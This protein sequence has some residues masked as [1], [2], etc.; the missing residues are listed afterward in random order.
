MARNA[1]PRAGEPGPQPDPAASRRPRQRSAL[2]RTHARPGTLGR[3]V[4]PALRN[5]LSAATASSMAA[6]SRWKRP[7]SARRA[8]RP[9]R[10][11]CGSRSVY[12][13]RMKP[14]LKYR[15]MLHVGVGAAML[16]ALSGCMTAKLEESRNTTT[17]IAAG[18]AVVLLAKPHVEGITAEDDFM[19]CVGNKLRHRPAFRCGRTTRSSTRCSPGSN[20]RRRRNARRA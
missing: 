4:A 2:R 3:S 10:W 16:L 15:S 13:G 14:I 8:F 7:F 6:Q 5:R 1:L 20:R 17:S 18:E 11:N 12:S 9:T 19:D